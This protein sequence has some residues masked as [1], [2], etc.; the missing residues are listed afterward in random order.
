M[1]KAWPV[2]SESKLVDTAYGQTYVRISGP[3]NAPPLVLLPGAGA[4]SLQWLH[5]IEALSQSYRT[6]AVDA[7]INL[8]CVGK[9]VYTRPILNAEDLVAWLNGLFDKLDLKKNINLLG[10]SYGGGLAGHYA[11]HAPERLHKVVLI[12]PSS[13]VLPFRPSYF[14]RSML[15]NLF[16]KRSIYLRF[17]NYSFKN[18]AQ[19][20]GDFLEDIADDFMLSSQSFVPVNPKEL[21]LLKVFTDEAMQS[22]H[23]PTLFLVGEHDVL[24]SAVKAV[25]RL[26]AI[27]PQMQAEIIPDAGHDLLL[28]QTDLVNQKVVEFL[29]E[30]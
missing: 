5:N 4:C 19:Q 8:G 16:P 13:V 14:L 28:V 10:A 25:T 12:A 18:L 20:N 26:H 11:L 24:Y 30:A 3:A 27:A 15:I 21:P 29:A 2:P 1:E 6:Y 17:F 23:L 9:S 22:I 7:L